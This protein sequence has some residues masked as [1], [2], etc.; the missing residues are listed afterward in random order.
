MRRAVGAQ[1]A[2]EESARGSWRGK[3]GIAVL[4]LTDTATAID[5]VRLPWGY[6]SGLVASTTV[7]PPSHAT[8]DRCVTVVRI[9]HLALLGGGPIPA[10][11]SLLD[12]CAFYD[13]FGTPG[14]QVGAWVDSEKVGFARTLSFAPPDSASAN[15]NRWGYLDYVSSEADFAR[16][17]SNDLSAC[18]RMLRRP[19]TNFYWRYWVDLS[20]PAPAEAI[21]L[22]QRARGFSATLLD[23]MVRDIGP[24]RFERVWQS[25][26]SLDSAYF[27]ATGEQL[28]SWVH[29]RAV[30]LDGAYHIGPLPTAT[31]A[32]L[33]IV[34]IV[35]SLALSVRFAQRPAAA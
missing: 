12:G 19:A 16:C 28:S 32:I 9:G 14:P 20:V 23:A 1:L 5:G 30:A 18:S 10:D 11:R 13:A 26:R 33:T 29:R 8:G 2:A 4:V 35:L 6:N 3:G 25:P 21:E 22:T 15:L 17:A 7:L 24:E 31:S 34:T 27:D